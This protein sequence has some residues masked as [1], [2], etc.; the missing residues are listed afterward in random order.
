M[1]VSIYWLTQATEKHRGTIKK[2]VAGLDADK[3]GRYD[4]AA[5][6]EAIFCGAPLGGNGEFVSTPEAVRQLTLAKKTQIE[7]QN[8]KFREEFYPRDFVH[9]TL[10]H[11]NAIVT[12]TLKANCGR[13]LTVETVNDIFSQ[14]REAFIRM[15]EDG[16]RLEKEYEKEKEEKAQA[17][18]GPGER[19]GALANDRCGA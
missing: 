7:L 14:F 1:R 3:H 10:K 9:F 5:A 4:S 17:V 12:Q 19:H 18:N 2:R 6:L 15:R 13:F 8:A 16:D 11:A